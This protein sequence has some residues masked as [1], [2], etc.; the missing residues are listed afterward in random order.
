[1]N[2]P[3]DHQ[4]ILHYH[5]ISCLWFITNLHP[6][7]PG[8]PPVHCRVAIAGAQ[9]QAVALLRPRAVL[10]DHRLGGDVVDAWCRNA[11]VWT[12]RGFPWGKMGKWDEKMGWNLR[13][14][15]FEYWKMDKN[16]MNHHLDISKD[17]FL[18]RFPE[19]PWDYHWYWWTS[20][21]WPWEMMKIFGNQPGV[22][23]VGF[24]GKAVRIHPDCKKGQY[25]HD[26]FSP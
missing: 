17:P 11:A 5:F 1:M 23:M 10:E 25:F 20:C 12:P 24:E 8:C 9:H 15:I 22:S 7:P 2:L 21:F 19:I 6:I 4:S 18:I 13:N 14:I 26:G 3:I 16:G